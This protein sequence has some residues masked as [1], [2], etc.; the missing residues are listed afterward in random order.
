MSS[1]MVLDVS[2]FKFKSYTV[3]SCFSTGSKGGDNGSKIQFL[4][5]SDFG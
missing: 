5:V 4:G 1:V 2:I 3:L